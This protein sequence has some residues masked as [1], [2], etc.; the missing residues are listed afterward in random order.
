M[1]DEEIRENIR[2]RLIEC[3]K[4]KGLTQTEVGDILGKAK[5][6]VATWEQ[7]KTSPDIAQLFRLAAYYQKTIAYMYGENENDDTEKK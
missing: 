3:R 2:K 4:E 5:T 6:T 1:T 7:G